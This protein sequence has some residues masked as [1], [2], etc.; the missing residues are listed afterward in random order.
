MLEAIAR[1]NAACLRLPFSQYGLCGAMPDQLL[2]AMD[3][4]YRAELV[5]AMKA[6]GD[7]ARLEPREFAAFRDPSRTS[8]GRKARS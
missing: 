8:G 2:S 7:E 6:A 5:K 3:R 4:A 1:L